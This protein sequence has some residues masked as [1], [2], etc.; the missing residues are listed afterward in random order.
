MGQI[1]PG[2]N[3]RALKM[4]EQAITDEGEDIAYYLRLEAAV[5]EPAD[6]EILR[7]VM[8]DDEKHKKLLE[9]IYESI[10][11]QKYEAVFGK[12]DPEKNIIHEYEIN[13]FYKLENADFY[14]KIHNVFVN[15]EIRDVLL[16]IITDE[17]S[18][19]QKFTYLYSK[20]R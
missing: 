17:F 13:I 5:N 12:K 18:H 3:E 16:E 2:V 9:K 15:R 6:K 14:R 10:S 7:Q 11:G 8:L 4:L 19:A 20:Y 1:I